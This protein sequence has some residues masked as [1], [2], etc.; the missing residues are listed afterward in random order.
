MSFWKFPSVTGGNISS[1][2]NAGL[3]TFRD[4]PIDSLTR[5]ICQNS[6]DAIKDPEKPVVVEFKKF[7]TSGLPGKTDLYEAFYKGKETWKNGNE[8]SLRFINSALSILSDSNIECLRISDFN[9][10]GLLGAEKAE[11]GSPWSSLIKEAGSSNKKDDSGGSF[12]IGKAAP[13]LSS[14]LRTLF[15]SSFDKEGYLS[16]IGV[17]D[18]MSFRKEDDS[19]TLGKGYFTDNENSNAIPSVLK[20]DPYFNR[21]E[22]GTDIFVMAFNGMKDWKNEMI[23]SILRNFFLT[24]FQRKLVVNVDG[25]EVNHLNVADLING[26][27][28]NNENQILKNYFKLLTSDQT[29]KVLYP[30]K[31]YKGGIEFEEG[32]A[33]LLLLDGE[34]LNRRVLMTRKTG[35]RIFEQS[36]ISGSISFTGLLFMKGKNMNRVF[37][38]M[39]NPA[40]DAWISNRFEENPKL[41]ENIFADLRRF[42]RDTVKETYHQEVAD[43]MN[44]IGLS[45]F[46]PNKK[47]LEGKGGEKTESINSRAKSFEVKEIRQKSFNHNETSN[48]DKAV[49]P[50]QLL[51]EYGISEGELGGNGSGRKNGEGGSLPD[52]GV[53]QQGGTNGKDSSTKGDVDIKDKTIPK[54]VPIYSKQRYACISK[55]SGEYRF[56]IVPQKKIEKGFIKF[57]LIGEQNNFDLPI[58]KAS[59]NNQEIT[60]EKVSGNTIHFNNPQK[61]TDFDLK[62]IIE[63]SDYCVME[64]GVYENS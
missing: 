50:E 32:E 30:A 49:T 27:E 10:V 2:N 19:V 56:M 33:E 9:T 45:D 22:T 54:T 35:M 15:Y 63:Y 41:G 24:V 43:T 64:A 59:F 51:G 17:A 37:K 4:N 61:Q 44:A 11:L 40:H 7:I 18:I 58:Q 42:I 28:D 20:L 39:E 34:D 53:T 14:N 25:F 36:N 55:E 57:K 16:H 47:M 5:E 46:L 60:V 52:N 29:I 38:Q 23:Q 62:I 1:I 3:E 31:K 13:F 26:L 21:K 6:L 48:E 8:K 12:G